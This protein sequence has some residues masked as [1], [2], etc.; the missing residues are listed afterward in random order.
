MCMYWFI[1]VYTYTDLFTYCLTHMRKHTTCMCSNPGSFLHCRV[2]A[3]SCCAVRQAETKE[4]LASPW[5]CWVREGL[6]AARTNATRVTK[7]DATRVLHA[8]ESIISL[9]IYQLSI[10]DF[11]S[12]LTLPLMNCSLTTRS[13]ISWAEQACHLSDKMPCARALNPRVLLQTFI[14]DWTTGNSVCLNG[15]WC[16]YWF[17]DRI[18][19]CYFDSK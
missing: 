15:K 1:N 16:W 18:L 17:H 19:G 12:C 3:V 8:H 6:L 11:E 4:R 10:Q 5:C 9:L 7:E 2:I 14:Q 13:N